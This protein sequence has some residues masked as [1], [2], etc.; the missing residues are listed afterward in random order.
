MDSLSRVLM[1]IT[2]Q[3]HPGW[4]GYAGHPLVRTP[5]LDRLASEGINFSRA[6]TPGPLCMPAR[7]SLFTGQS[8]RAHGVRMNGIPLDPSVPTFTEALRRRGWDTHCSG[9]IH[10]SPGGL[11][12]GWD[13]AG[14]DPLA[15]PESRA[16]WDA[17][18]IT[19][20][21]LPYYGLAGADFLGGCAHGTYG[22]Y[23]DWLRETDPDAWDAFLTRRALEEPSP[24][25]ELFNR[26][27]WQWDLPAS[28][29]PAAWVADR[30]IDFLR[31]PRRGD[32]PWL[33][34]C[35]IQEPHPPFAP[36]REYARRYRPEDIPP[37]R[38][39]LP[40]W[41][42]LPPHL[43]RMREEALVSSG[44]NGQPMNATD[45]WRT[46]CAAHYAGLIELVDDQV[47]RVLNVLE[48]TGQA[49]DTL[50]LFL[51]DHGEGLGDHGLWGKGAYHYDEIIRVPL[52]ARWPGRIAP[53]R[54]WD[55]PVGLTDLAPTILSL[56]GTAPLEGDVPPE[57]EA[58]AA[59]PVMSGTDLSP[60]LEGSGGDPDRA[61]VVESDEDYLAERLRTLVSRDHRLTWYAGRPYGELYDLRTDPEEMTNLWDDPASRPVKDA[62]TARLLDE[63]IRTDG[64]LPRQRTRA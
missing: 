30:T 61:V 44:N 12:S 43:R 15:W 56:A 52:L 46:E 3:F 8:P 20:L 4:L 6:Y 33:H 1:I 22:P 64:V 42:G 26:N 45:P 28:R 18:I 37:P 10:L 58:P 49:E 31:N 40:D 13:P 19:G 51:A 27:S 63:I 2:D 53:G 32:R 59:P 50:V 7:A 48:E 54:I 57:P 21:P 55:G 41:A 60:V 29:H 38:G 47:G 16:L 23:T 5:N 35:S 9:K 36:P 24:A 11:T 17:G 62:L 25:A 34:M 14:A 39:F